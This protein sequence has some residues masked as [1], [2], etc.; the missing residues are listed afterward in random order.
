MLTLNVSVILDL[1]KDVRIYEWNKKIRKCKTSNF[2]SEN[3]ILNLSDIISYYAD[4]P[5]DITA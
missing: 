1:H 5:Y 4:I 2:F 3:S